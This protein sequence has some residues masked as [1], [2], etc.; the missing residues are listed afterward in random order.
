LEALIGIITVSDSRSTGENVDLSGPAVA[1]ALEELGYKRFVM[2]IIPD[3]AAL[4]RLTLV[5]MAKEC[6]AIFTTGGTGFTPRDVTPDATA[7]VLDRRADN[8]CELIRLRGL[9]KTPMSHLSR[10]VAGMIGRTLVVNLPGSPK[11]AREGVEAIG[12]L[13]GPILS[14][15]AGD[16]C[17][18]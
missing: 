18:H 10:G 12:E 2:K 5:A 4:I 1:Q 9:E 13:I 8:L 11:G 6:G 14:A 16:G 7:A 17:P 15:I 3:E